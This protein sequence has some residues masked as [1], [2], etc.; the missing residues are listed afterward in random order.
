[1]RALAHVEKIKWIKPIDG[2]DKIELAGV[3]GWQCVV[4]KDEFNVGDLCVYIEID[5]LVDAENPV[6]AF[7]ESRKYKIKTIKLKGV[8][9]QGILFPL[10][11]LPE[12]NHYGLG[13]DVTDILKIQKVEDPPIKQTDEIAK[14]S[15]RR[16]KKILK[17][18]LVSRLMRFPV[19]RK[20]IVKCLT[21]KPIK[22][23]EWVKKADEVRIQSAPGILEVFA[24]TPM[25][26]TEKLDGT[27]TSFGLK[28]L[29][30]RKYDF[31]ICSMN[32]RLPKENKRF[33]STDVYH[34]VSTKYDIENVLKNLAEIYYADT[35][36]LQG[37]TIGIGIQGNKYRLNDVDFYGFNLIIDGKKINSQAASEVLK[38]FGIKWVP[39]IST[40]FKLLPTVDE[41]V[42][43][44][45]GKSLLA[46]TLREGVVIRDPDNLV[47]FKCVSNK[48]LLKHDI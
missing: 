21:P 32:F 46:D 47:S 42:E 36:V 25:I 30:R 13:D 40:D 14:T 48:F 5:S 39:I 7:L 44:A 4:K 38:Q 11:I 6:F 19:F 9:S 20:W 24:T 10:S 31:A 27:S 35:V 12:G 33:P 26:V 2:A 3:L 17:N 34:T 1:M 29:S 23:P 37:E 8:I 28:K 18:P 15:Q 41:M 43:Y 22:R 16:Y 45:D